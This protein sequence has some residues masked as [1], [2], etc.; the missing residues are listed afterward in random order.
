MTGNPYYLDRRI[1][2]APMMDWTDRHC[3]YFL[4]QIAPNVLLFTEMITA[5]ALIHGDITKLLGHS[6]SEAPLVLQLGGCQ[7]KRLAKAVMLAKKWGFAEINLNVGCPSN[8]VQSGRFGACLMKEPEL[9]AACCEAMM[10]NTDLPISVKCRI[11]ID[12]MDPETGLDE[13]IDVVSSS[14]VSVFYLHARKAWLTG[15]N[16]KENRTI[17]PL[18]YNRVHRLAARRKD[19]TFILNGGLVSCD[20]AFYERRELGG[21]M[22]GR[23]AYR[24]PYIL[25]EL[26][27]RIHGTPMPLRKDVAQSMADY[28]AF[29]LK[30]GVP[31]HKITR[32]MLGLYSGR[33]GAKYWRRR[34]GES[35]RSAIDAKN[36]I[37]ET[38]ERCERLSFESAA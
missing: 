20:Q 12:D 19:L 4:R 36:F 35:V 2:V 3:R 25:A 37:I 9:V 8:R 10:K 32:H 11:G 23:A 21:V 7:P 6:A 31:L 17:P 1:C 38:A 29:Y 13:F 14:N 34:I 30:S 15:L 27:L 28:A 5:E 26:A 16:P 22:L 33:P 24:T 18:D